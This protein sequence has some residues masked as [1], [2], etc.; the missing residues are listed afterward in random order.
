MV[1]SRMQP[2]AA[3]GVVRTVDASR[4]AGEPFPVSRLPRHPPTQPPLAWRQAE[5]GG[6]Q[7]A[8]AAWVALP[9]CAGAACATL[10]FAEGLRRQWR[11][12]ALRRSCGGSAKGQR[13]PRHCSSMTLKARPGDGYSWEEDGRHAHEVK[14]YVPISDEVSCRD[15]DFRLREGGIL[16]VGVKGQKP[17]IDG[18]PLWGSVDAEESD[19]MVERREGCR[20]VVVT[21]T[22]RNVRESWEFLLKK[23]GAFVGPQPD[24][25]NARHDW[26]VLE[27]MDQVQHLLQQHRLEE[28]Q[29]VLRTMTAG[30]VEVTDGRVELVNFVGRGRGWRAAKQIKA[31]DVLLYD[32]AFCFSRC[33]QDQYDNMGSQCMRKSDDP[34]FKG[35]VMSL[36][37]ATDGDRSLLGILKNNTFEC[38]REPG[39]IAFFVSAARFNHS[40]CPN[41]FFDA[42]QST[43]IV[44]ALRD[45][46]KGEE[47]CISY[48]PVSD[49]WESRRKQLQ[50]FGFE[51][52]CERCHEAAIGSEPQTR[53]T[54]RCG[55]ASFSVSSGAPKSQTCPACGSSFDREDSEHCLRTLSSTNAYMRS[56]EA[57]EVDPAQLARML[58]AFAAAAEPPS[59]KLAG[60]AGFVVSDSL[61]APPCHPESLQLLDNLASCHYAVAA[62]SVPGLARDS[63]LQKYWRYKLQYIERRAE[64][65]GAGNVHRDV[66]YVRELHQA[67]LDDLPTPSAAEKLRAELGKVCKLQF[68]QEEVPNKLVESMRPSEPWA[69]AGRRRL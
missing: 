25:V 9:A 42:S 16:T 31:G 28:A 47:V 40:C 35:E 21:L 58:S 64:N 55:E 61:R 20:S 33:G 4:C 30:H 67:L 11:R 6:T 18:E 5:H 13:F 15:V 14:I 38:S 32:T 49:S 60:G 45:I 12:R 69:P 62:R 2:G 52:S 26:A 54:C 53:V 63:A 59:A 57:R 44:R 8:A 51:C 50:R 34:F 41:A 68:G 27:Q 46:P 29:E 36:S 19:W 7:A 37:G 10:A 56:P 17:V 43:G 24:L 1:Q 65:H 39:Y 3:F 66:G 22:K 48:V 23:E